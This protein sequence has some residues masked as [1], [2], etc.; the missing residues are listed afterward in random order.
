[1]PR[2]QSWPFCCELSSRRLATR[3]GPGNP[4]VHGLF[5]ARPTAAGSRCGQPVGLGLRQGPSH[6][7]GLPVSNSHA[8]GACL[9]L[10]ATPRP[11]ALSMHASGASQALPLDGAMTAFC[12]AMKGR[13]KPSKAA[14]VA[15]SMGL[16]MSGT[17]ARPTTVGAMPGARPARR[18]AARAVATMRLIVKPGTMTEATDCHATTSTAVHTASVRGLRPRS[19]AVAAA[20]RDLSAASPRT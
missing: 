9:P 3:R 13:T 17:A 8:Q 16:T 6:V 7:D 20:R 19:S 1:M 18:S 10:T 14:S 2:S 11:R 4:G 5:G 15:S 12:L